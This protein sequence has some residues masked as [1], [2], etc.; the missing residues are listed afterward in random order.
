MNV[1]DV[2]ESQLIDGANHFLPQNSNY[3]VGIIRLILDDIVRD[4]KDN[5]VGA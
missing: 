4:T 1:E 5:V 3:V 2:R